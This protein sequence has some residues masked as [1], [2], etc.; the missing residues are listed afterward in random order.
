MKRRDSSDIQCSLQCLASPFKRFT[1][2][3]KENQ[4][5]PSSSVQTRPQ[6]AAKRRQRN[7]T[8][9]LTTSTSTTTTASQPIQTP[10]DQPNLCIRRHRFKN[11]N[12][13]SFY[14]DEQ[15]E[16]FL[17][18]LEDIS[19]YLDRKIALTEESE[20]T[21]KEIVDLDKKQV[22]TSNNGRAVYRR[23]RNL[24]QP[25]FFKNDLLKMTEKRFKILIFIKNIIFF[26][27]I[28]IRL[29]IK[30]I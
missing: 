5:A 22:V 19:S 29:F 1:D 26:F 4:L 8:T 13:I 2:N 11:S 16:Q 15:L 27:S 10:Q 3:E 23:T 21:R 17:D 24:T 20:N 6:S 7:L 18:S 12:I 30:N 9:S 25:I 14:R 28:K